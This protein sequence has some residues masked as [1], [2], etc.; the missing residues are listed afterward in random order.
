MSRRDWPK[1]KITGR[2]LVTYKMTHL[3]TAKDEAQKA[4]TWKEPHMVPV[5]AFDGKKKEEEEAR[6]W[7]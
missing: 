1:K 5:Q 3:W 2:T 7:E 4:Q 6:I